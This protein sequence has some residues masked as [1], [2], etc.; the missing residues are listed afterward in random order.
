MIYLWTDRMKTCVYCNYPDNPTDAVFC[1]RCQR[2]MP[3]T[4]HVLIEEP[5][6]KTGV[7]SLLEPP[8]IDPQ[9][10]LIKKPVGLSDLVSTVLEGP[11][12]DKHVDK[13]GRYDIALYIA[14][15]EEPLIYTVK[16][17]TIIGRYGGEFAA[18]PHIDLAAFGALQ[19]GVSRQ[20][21][22]LRRFGPDVGIIDLDSRNGTWL[23]GVRLNP[24]QSFML[25]NGDRVLLAHLPVYIYMPPRYIPT[26]KTGQLPAI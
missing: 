6:R 1:V 7:T 15:M 5:P 16:T 24:R 17:D 10:S 2:A 13:L 12:R 11:K 3:I 22:L 8:V 4:R 19:R 9:E 26:G 14:D 23:N 18:Q 25:R 20:H 21:A